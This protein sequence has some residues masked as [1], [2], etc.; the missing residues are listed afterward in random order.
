MKTIGIYARVSTARQ[1][2]EHTIESQVKAIERHVVEMGGTIDPE[3]RYIDDGWSG[4][5]LRR[6]GLDALRDAVAQER[7]DC[8]VL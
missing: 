4:A 7:L 3:H 1:E 2:Q 6:P 8:V 5:T